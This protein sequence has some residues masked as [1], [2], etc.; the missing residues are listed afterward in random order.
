MICSDHTFR[1]N[2]ENREIQNLYSIA[3]ISSEVDLIFAGI[4]ESG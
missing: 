4:L 3:A 1:E 2:R